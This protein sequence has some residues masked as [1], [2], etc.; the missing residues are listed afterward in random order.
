MFAFRSAILEDECTVCVAGIKNFLFGNSLC[1]FFTE[2]SSV[3]G[4]LCIT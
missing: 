4:L 1:I 2:E 3:P